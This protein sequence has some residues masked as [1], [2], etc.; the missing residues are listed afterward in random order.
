MT[1]NQRIIDY[2]EAARSVRHLCPNLNWDDLLILGPDEDILQY[3]DKCG[4]ET[5]MLIAPSWIDDEQTY[6]IWVMH[7]DSNLSYP[8][9]VSTADVE[10]ARSIAR[11]QSSNQPNADVLVKHMVFHKQFVQG[12]YIHFTARK[13]D[14]DRAVIHKMLDD[15]GFDPRDYP[16]FLNQLYKDNRCVEDDPVALSIMDRSIFWRRKYVQAYLDFLYKAGTQPD[17]KVYLIGFINELAQ[18]LRVH[19]FEVKFSKEV[20]N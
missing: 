9:E 19:D 1:S 5:Q 20:C 15:P 4:S 6:K 10:F 7:E 18:E 3:I 12:D 8:L 16:A 11:I 14:V 13:F 17:Q 2:T